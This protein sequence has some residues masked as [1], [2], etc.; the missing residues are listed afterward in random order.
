V[1][2]ED[3]VELDGHALPVRDLAFSPD[4]TRLVTAGEDRTLVIWDVTTTKR[5][6]GFSHPS[7]VV[8]CQ[9]SS[10]AT[11]S[12]V[13]VSTDGTTIVW[14]LPQLRDR[15]VVP[16]EAA[17]ND[18]SLSE[19]GQHIILANE[20]GVVTVRDL[21]QDRADPVRCWVGHD[22]PR[23]EMRAAVVNL[24]DHGG[25]TTLLLTRCADETLCVWD[26]R[27]GRM[28]ER[29]HAPGDVNFAVSPRG[30]YFATVDGQQ[31]YVWDRNSGE[32][33][34]GPRGAITALAAVP[35]TAEGPE[36]AGL[37]VGYMNGRIGL[38]DSTTG[39][40]RWH[41]DVG[42]P[43]HMSAISTDGK[44]GYTAADGQLDRWQLEP[45]PR[46]STGRRMPVDGVPLPGQPLRLSLP[47]TPDDARIL[48]VARDRSGRPGVTVWDP[49]SSGNGDPS[50]THAYPGPGT[51]QDACLSAD[52]RSALVLVRTAD[53]ACQLLVWDIGSSEVA[54]HPHSARVCGDEPSGVLII[55]TDQMLTYGTGAARLWDLAAGRLIMTAESKTPLDSAG[56]LDSTGEAAFSIARDGTIRTWLVPEADSRTGGLAHETGS[57][58]SGDL[59]VHLWDA[60]T[61]RALTASETGTA[62]VWSIEDART[63]EPLY[64]IDLGGRPVAADYGADVLGVAVAN[65][66]DSQTT[67]HLYDWAT[68][69]ELDRQRLPQ[70]VRVLS[71]SR[72]GQYVA[73]ASPDHPVRIFDTRS[74]RRDGW[75]QVARGPESLAQIGA[76]EFSPSGR[77]LLAA[78]NRGAIGIWYIDATAP[79]LREVIGVEGHVGAV[80]GLAFSRDAAGNFLISWGQDE[81]AVVHF[82]AGWQ[83]DATVP[84]SG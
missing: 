63:V 19:T 28:L 48:V 27:S 33:R 59:A 2:V 62:T 71:L 51:P 39:T 38:W 73:V 8:A 55:A 57:A 9:F 64:A 78:D 25:P 84:D 41:G 49:A 5:V 72:D 83:H 16:A 76:I 45:P 36:F 82:T 6:R 13:S 52:G 34:P 53:E 50:R 14:P 7:P 47:Q 23:A 56:F 46:D 21:D 29:Y 75:R 12:L 80:Q 32:R 40:D 79:V 3:A 65:N 77:R 24:G 58:F 69:R 31:A 15:L 18:A 81:Q 30:R 60:A 43:V 66:E 42:R 20:G 68:G 67:V 61:R 37:L 70:S 10:A 44:W 11:E 74:G 22:D 17:V 26:G 4:G 1:T 54:A 35:G